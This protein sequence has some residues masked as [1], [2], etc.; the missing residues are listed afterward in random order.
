MLFFS[1]LLIWREINV[2]GRGL[3]VANQRNNL[4][5][6]AHAKWMGCCSSTSTE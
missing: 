2:L 4:A 1:T 5:N 3:D 6:V